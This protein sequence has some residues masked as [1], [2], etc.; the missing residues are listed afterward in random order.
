MWFFNFSMFVLETFLKELIM[1]NIIIISVIFLLSYN[2][3]AQ[4]QAAA[5]AEALA[6]QLANPVANLISVPLQN[7][8]DFNVGPLEGF[9][10]N[11]NIQP[12]IPVSIGENWNMISRTIIP[13]ISQNDVTAKGESEFG[14]GDVAQSIFFSPK[15]IK[16]GL[17]WGVGPIFL[18]PTATDDALGLNKWAIGPNALVLK[19][20]GQWTYG[21]L[22]NHM[23]SFAGSGNNDIN[24]TFFQPFATY[25]TPEG[26]SYTIA[27][28]NTQDWD[29]DI[30]G[31]FIGIY[32]AKVLKFGTQM[33][34]LGGG[35]KVYYGNNI[36]NPQWGIRV[37][38]ILLFPK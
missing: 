11:L 1:K 16:N 21:A 4:T 33:V 3:N 20:Q 26:A 37:N 31:G 38:V 15:E 18:I 2:L 28:E 35:P 5:S 30:F 10:Y 23:W 8:F 7:N 14:L 27:S 36:F 25:A 32:Y 29:N 12:V 17:V 24:A 22:V 6:K 9:K 19:I 13:I 34:Q